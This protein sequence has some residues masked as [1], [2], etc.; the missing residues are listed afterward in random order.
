MNFPPAISPLLLASL[1]SLCLSACDQKKDESPVE[2]EKNTNAPQ[3]VQAATPSP[4]ATSN[5]P[6]NQVID[7]LRKKQAAG[8]GSGSVKV[9]QAWTYNGYSVLDAVPGARLVAVD[10]TITGHTPA[11]DFDDIE[12]ID[13]SSKMSYGSDPHLTLLTPEGKLPTPKD[14]PPT[15]GDPLRVL[16][17]YGFPKKTR[18]FT[19]YYW[20]KNLLPKNH[21]IEPSG[22]ELPFPKNKP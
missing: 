8:L 17:I 21:S 5:P 20:G 14:P 11:F 18:S 9:N 6:L 7:G 10:V 4:K 16:L 19:L 12:I 1:L 22:W 15:A 3:K 2:I 13:G